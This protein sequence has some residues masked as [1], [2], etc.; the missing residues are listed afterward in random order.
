MTCIIHM[1]VA[2]KHAFLEELWERRTGIRAS[3]HL[4]CL[5]CDMHMFV[6][7][8]YAFLEELW[9]R[10]KGVRATSSIGF[11][12]I[13]QAGDPKGV[14]SEPVKNIARAQAAGMD[15]SHQLANDHHSA[16]YPAKSQ[17]HFGLECV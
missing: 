11:A 10:R 1:F 16:K 2:C 7:C 14:L 6:A 3:N 8:R 17:Q 12:L 5:T 4:W 13:E 15:P 9:E